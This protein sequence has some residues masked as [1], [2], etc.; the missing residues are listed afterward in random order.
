[1]KL[2]YTLSEGYQRALRKEGAPSNEAGSKGA[3][4]GD[5]RLKSTH[6]LYALNI[7]V[8]ITLNVLGFSGTYGSQLILHITC[9]HSS[10]LCSRLSSSIIIL[11]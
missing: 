6:V 5:R 8:L 2:L 11:K 4:D 10:F 3:V 1:M 7:N 9:T